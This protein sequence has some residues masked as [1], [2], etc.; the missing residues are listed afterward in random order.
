MVEELEGEKLS[1]EE[2][3]KTILDSLEVDRKDKGIMVDKLATFAGSWKL[4]IAFVV[5]L[6]LWV[7]INIFLY[8]KSFDPY[9]FILLNL[10]LSCTATIQGPI[11]MMSQNRQEAKDRIR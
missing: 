7:F 5:I 11:L 9:P 3:L 8:E 10:V 1:K 4:I 2:L 6:I